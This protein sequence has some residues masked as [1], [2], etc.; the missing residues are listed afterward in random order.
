MTVKTEKTTLITLPE[1]ARK[2]N[3]RPAYVRR[4]ARKH[5]HFKSYDHH[6]WFWDTK[7]KTDQKSIAV[8]NELAKSLAVKKPTVKH[9]PN[10]PTIKIPNISKLDKTLVNLYERWLDEQKYESIAEYAIPIAKRIKTLKLRIEIDHMVSKPFGF[11]WFHSPTNKHYQ[12]IV[13]LSGDKKSVVIE[14]QYPVSK[15]QMK[16]MQLRKCA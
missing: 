11:V 13:K 1:I 14:N 5:D 6:N 16:H 3:V 7:N 10:N 2:H 12:T 4:L 15:S 8:V 9:Q